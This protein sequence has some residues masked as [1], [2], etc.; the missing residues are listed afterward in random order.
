MQL[1]FAFRF[2]G[3]EREIDLSPPGC[4]PEFDEWRWA[5]LAE[6]PGLIVPFKRGVYHQVV[7]AFERFAG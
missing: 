1:W 3:E 6:T 5:D 4:K 2:T 7:R